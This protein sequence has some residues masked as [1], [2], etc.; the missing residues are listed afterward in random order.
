MMIFDDM[1]M[2]WGVQLT[3]SPPPGCAWQGAGQGGQPQQH[4]G[5]APQ[6]GPQIQD[7]GQP[8]QARTPLS[9]GV[10]NP[11][12]SCNL[13]RR[14]LVSLRSCRSTSCSRNDEREQAWGL[15]LH[16][17]HLLRTNNQYHSVSISIIQ[18]HSVSYH[19]ILYHLI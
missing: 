17:K 1:E 14:P 8:H 18:Y 6:S 19:L 7:T 11:C 5:A 9:L 13:H 16:C 10:C 4:P 15:P 3:S 12:N 2:T